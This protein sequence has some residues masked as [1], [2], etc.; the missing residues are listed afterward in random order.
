MY[1]ADRDRKKGKRKGKEI[2]RWIE[3]RREGVGKGCPLTPVLQHFGH[4]SD[5]Y[6]DF[7]HLAQW[8]WAK[9]KLYWNKEHHL[10]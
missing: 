7:Q 5:Y 4:F 1:K 8:L 9:S 10:F 3:G 2:G 6:K